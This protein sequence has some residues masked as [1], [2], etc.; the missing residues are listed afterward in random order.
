MVMKVYSPEF[1]ADTV[2][3][4]LSDPSHTFEG[5]GKDFQFVEDHHHAWGAKRL[6]QVLGV[7]RSSFYKWRAGRA[8]RAARERADAVLAERITAVHAERDGTYGRPRITAELRDDGRRRCSPLPAAGRDRP[9]GSTPHGDH[10]SETPQDRS[11]PDGQRETR[12]HLVSS[13][14]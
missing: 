13:S 10:G 7:A 3:L 6:C 2:A 5:I 9:L 1:K 14:E 11:T 4:Y 12:G 8:A